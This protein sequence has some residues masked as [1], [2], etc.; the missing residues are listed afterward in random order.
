MGPSG[1][2]LLEVAEKSGGWAVWEWS[3]DAQEGSRAPAAE[4][5]PTAPR[6]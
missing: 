6:R 5:S 2:F 1:H 3:A 4:P